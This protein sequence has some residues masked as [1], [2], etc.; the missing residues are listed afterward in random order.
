MNTSLNISLVEAF[1]DAPG[2]RY[3]WQGDFSGEEFRDSV[4]LPALN[5]NDSVVVNLDGALGLPSSFL[6]EAFGELTRT[7]PDLRAKLD[8]QIT[9]NSVA[10]VLLQKI[11]NGHPA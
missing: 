11:L 10:K 6:D 2:G 4:L 9:D 1:T 7:R 3:K 5:A 8:V